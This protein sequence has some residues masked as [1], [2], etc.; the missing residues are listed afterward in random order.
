MNEIKKYYTTSE[1]ANHCGV[2]FNAVARWVNKKRHHFPWQRD[3]KVSLDDF[4]LFIDQINLDGLSKAKENV[5]RALIVDDEEYTAKSIGRVFNNCGFNIFM[6]QNGFKAA[7]LLKQELPQIVTLDLSMNELNGY[8][9]LKIIKSIK[10]RQKAWII[11]I[12]G[13]SEDSF[14]KAI[15][16]GADFYLKKPFSKHDLEKIILKLYP[17]AS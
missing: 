11:I 7:V 6:A 4:I 10:L 3:Q 12:S 5:P 17:K 14:Q 8:D 1:V 16:M 13:N 2:S 15:E 9:V